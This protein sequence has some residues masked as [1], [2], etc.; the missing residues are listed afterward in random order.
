MADTPAFPRV[1]QAELAQDVL[2]QTHEV[3]QQVTEH[4]SEATIEQVGYR[5]QQISQE[6]TG[7]IGDNVEHDRVQVDLEP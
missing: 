2:E 4:P 1:L 7:G 6:S 3:V 5:A